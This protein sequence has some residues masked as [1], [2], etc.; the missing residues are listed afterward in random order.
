MKDD[1]VLDWGQHAATVLP[2]YVRNTVMAAWAALPSS[3]KGAFPPVTITVFL[4]WRQHAVTMLS[5]GAR[6]T[7]VAELFT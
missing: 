2:R 5:H 7:V 3:F 6:N 4:T 1:R